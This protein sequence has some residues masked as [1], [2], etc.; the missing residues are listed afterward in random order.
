MLFRS[1][2]P[3]LGTKFLNTPWR[4]LSDQ[5]GSEKMARFNSIRQSVQNEYARIIS[6]PSLVGTMSDSA[7]KEGEALL[8]PNA[9]VGQIR[10]ALD[11]LASEA[12]NRHES[13]QDQIKAIQSRI[14]GSTAEPEAEWKTKGDV[15]WRKIGQ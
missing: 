2:I 13:Y 4:A 5:L 15:K 6:S 8:A 12:K 10:A 3:D 11:T 1:E 7:R 14:G 9:T